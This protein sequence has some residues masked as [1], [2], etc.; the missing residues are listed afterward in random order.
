LEAAVAL[1]TRELATEKARAELERERA[2][3]ASRLKGEFLANMSHEIRTPMNGI[4][5]MTGLLLTTPLTS[6]QSEYANTVRNCGEHLLSVINDILDYSKIEAGHVE[7]ELA[8]FDL[9]DAIALVLD[10]TSLQAGAKGLRLEITYADSL[11]SSFEGDVGRVRQIL[12]NFVS[13]AIKFTSSGTVSILV[14]PLTGGSGI[15]FDVTD[16]GCGIPA[17]KLGLLFQQF[18]QADAS[19]TRRFGGTG[20][21]LAISKKLAEL[22]GGSVGVV[23]EPGIGSTFWVELPLRPAN[24][25]PP[26]EA[27]RQTSVD[28]L[29]SA[30]RVLVAEDNVVNQKLT[31]RML[32]KLGCACELASNGL[33]ALNL[34]SQGC[35]DV[36]LMDCQM[37]EMD[38]YEAASAIR[39]LEKGSDDDTSRIPIIAL[40]AHAGS[41]DRDRCLAAGM[42]YYLSKPVSLELL[43]QILDRAHARAALDPVTLT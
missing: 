32:Q 8:P 7:L 28:P 35:F 11:A 13:N 29:S 10:L 41:A 3:S 25:Q 16:T 6:E 42:D 12:M 20:L 5:G 17:H 18:V 43:R 36:I 33:D 37:P 39:R 31:V 19:T 26:I 22:M 34:Y 38:G 4:I 27:V 2:E 23:S 24:G 40:T 9:R 15:R 14:S 1:R 30:L 21:G